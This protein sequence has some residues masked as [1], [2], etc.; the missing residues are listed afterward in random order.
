MVSHHAPTPPPQNTDTSLGVLSS[1]SAFCFV[2][3]AKYR[4]ANAATNRRNLRIFRRHRLDMIIT[5]VIKRSY[6]SFV[7]PIVCNITMCPLPLVPT[8][9]SLYSYYTRS[10]DKA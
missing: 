5:K 2:Q 8:Y 7:S 4:K 6:G 1:L 9:C 10:R 3:P